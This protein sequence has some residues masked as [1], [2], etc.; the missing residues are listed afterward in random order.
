MFGIYIWETKLTEFTDSLE[1]VNEGEKHQRWYLNF[2]FSNYNGWWCLP[3]WG[4][5]VRRI[6]GLKSSILAM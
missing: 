5:G 6:S 2:G 1:V 4:K 3:R